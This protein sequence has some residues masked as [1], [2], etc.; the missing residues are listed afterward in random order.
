MMEYT[1]KLKIDFQFTDIRNAIVMNEY[2]S[3]H[4]VSFLWGLRL[5]V[6]DWWLIKAIYY[7]KANNS[8][9]RSFRPASLF[10]TMQWI[11][12]QNGTMLSSCPS[13]NPA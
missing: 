6:V 8:P 5:I 13:S 12:L 3:A 2:V 11:Q 9:T 4:I 10:G 7:I 1:N